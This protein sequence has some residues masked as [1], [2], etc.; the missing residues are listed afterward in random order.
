MGRN[1]QPIDILTATG[2]KHLTK[3]EISNRKEAEIKLGQTKLRCPDYVKKDLY[4]YKRWKEI[5]K[6]Y[7]DAE[8]VSG[9]DTGFLARYCITYSEYIEL[10]GRKK[11]IN[12]ISE[13][14]DDVENYIDDNENFENKVKK[15]LSDM[16]STEAILKI[17]AAIN[18]K[19][20]LLIKMED[21]S[22]LNP[23]AKV[24]NIPKSEKKVVDPLAAKGYGNV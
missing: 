24:K 8:F 6:I 13:N 18:K 9:G 5:M 10:I 15:Q 1:A 4:A 22:F 7:K 23:L 16:I 19:M 17:D 21:R 14:S 3:A 12:S 11:R 20:D 2:K